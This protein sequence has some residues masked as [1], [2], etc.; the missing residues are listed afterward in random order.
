MRHRDLNQA[1]C[2]LAR[3]LEAIGDAWSLLIVHDAMRGTRRFCEFQRNLGVAR[4]IL[5]ARL[6]KLVTQGVLE[7][8]PGEGA[9]HEYA[10]TE[11]GRSLHPVVVALRRWGETCLF[12]PG[13][14]DR[15]LVD[16]ANGRSGQDVEGR[17]GE[18][19]ESRRDD[20]Q[21]ASGRG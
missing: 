10:L 1:R 2:P 3:S 13:E 7:V 8:V 12:E 15:P 16:P 19:S 11:K 21:G 14:L 9:Y 20:P 18:G 4:N 6:K 17:A 5:A